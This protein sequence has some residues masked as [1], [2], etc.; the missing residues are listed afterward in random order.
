MCA[1]ALSNT[2]FVNTTDVSHGGQE[3]FLLCKKDYSEVSKEMRSGHVAGLVLDRAVSGVGED[4]NSLNSAPPTL[5]LEPP[6]VKMRKYDM[7]RT[8]SASNRCPAC[9]VMVGHS[10]SLLSLL[11]FIYFTSFPLL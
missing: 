10:R 8:F 4:E 11:H 5:T 6:A 7:R 1:C 3:E 9:D 2:N